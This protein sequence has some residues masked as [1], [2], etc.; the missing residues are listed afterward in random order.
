[1]FSAG[2]G[3]TGTYIAIDNLTE[4][5]NKAGKVDVVETVMKLRRNRKDMVQNAVRI[6]DCNLSFSLLLNFGRQKV[7]L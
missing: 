6:F 3:R 2:A 7:L 1:L 5:F 4:E